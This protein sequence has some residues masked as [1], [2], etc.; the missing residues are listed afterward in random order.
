M[1]LGQI[2]FTQPLLTIA[3]NVTTE[4]ILWI[5]MLLYS[6]FR[7]RIDLMQAGSVSGILQLRMRMRIRIQVS[8]V[9]LIVIL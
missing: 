9:N 3:F 4:I 1:F 5:H 2:L 6:G 8:T 7:I